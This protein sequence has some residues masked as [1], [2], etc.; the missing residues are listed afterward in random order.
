[1]RLRN[2]V[3]GDRRAPRSQAYSRLLRD[4][5]LRSSVSVAADT[6]SIRS[7]TLSAMQASAGFFNTTLTISEEQDYYDKR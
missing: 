6:T 4:M 5:S 7:S 1:M 3:K 2:N